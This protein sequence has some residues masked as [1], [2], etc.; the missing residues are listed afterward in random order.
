MT[1]LV[2]PAVSRPARAWLGAV[3]GLLL[4][5]G[6]AA[7]ASFPTGAP[8][9]TRLLPPGARLAASAPVDGVRVLLT[10]QGGEL[11]GVV[12]WKGEKGWHG[13]DLDPVPGSTAAA[14]STTAGEGPVPALSVVYGRAP[15]RVVGVGWADGRRASV[16]TEEDGSYV[17]ARP[18]RHRVARVTV[19]DERGREVL[20]VTEL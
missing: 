15:G 16:R 19:A 12:A 1:A 18:G 3:A 14:W 20:E 11:V 10:V 4:A 17:V 8:G 6:L 9:P 2:L 5:V 7:V 13:I